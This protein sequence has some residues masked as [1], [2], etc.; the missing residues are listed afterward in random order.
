MEYILLPLL[1]NKYPNFR[2]YTKDATGNV[3]L[4]GIYA[5]KN[6]LN[7]TLPKLDNITSVAGT[8]FRFILAV[9]IDSN[10]KNP[11]FFTSEQYYSDLE[12]S[13]EDGNP[14]FITYSIFSPFIVNITIKDAIDLFAKL[15]PLEKDVP[16]AVIRN[17]FAS[18][19]D[20]N[21]KSFSTTKL[22]LG[23]KRI[24]L[25]DL[26]AKLKKIDDD[27]SKNQRIISESKFRA[28]LRGDNKKNAES[29]LE[30][31]KS[32]R[33]ATAASIKVLEDEINSMNGTG[34]IPP[35]TPGVEPNTFAKPTIPDITLTAED[36][37]IDYQLL[38]KY[39][40][41]M[42]SKTIYSI[43]TAESGGVEPAESIG[44]W[45]GELIDNYKERI[46]KKEAAKSGTSGIAGT[47]GTSVI[48]PTDNTNSLPMNPTQR[49]GG[50]RPT[51]DSNG[52]RIF[53][54]K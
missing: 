28:F 36:V 14:Y 25:D 26:N 17:V 18:G 32:D 20:K 31:L 41:W 47:S 5:D 44:E 51:F 46:A 49:G 45:A 15:D 23:A 3:I 9:Y 27:I 37:D 2:N 38:V 34:L 42:V 29:E 39:I 22:E 35:K 11:K 8:T 54:E 4:S 24:Q 33:T 30:K 40:D 7:F 48:Q 16:V 50:S 12:A 1:D 52:R 10:D 21:G 43:D 53:N 19:K 6:K 13:I